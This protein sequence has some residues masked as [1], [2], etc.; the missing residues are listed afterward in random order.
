MDPISI[1]TL[2]ASTT[3]SAYHVSATLYSFINGARRIDAEVEALSQE[4]TGV[5][6][7]LDAIGVVFA[8]PI[9]RSEKATSLEN[10]PIWAAVAG[11]LNDCRVSLERFD[12]QLS[13]SD[14]KPAGRSFL[15]QSLKWM[16]LSF[17]AES[18]DKLRFQMSTHTN[19]LQISLQMQSSVDTIGREY[20]K[21]ERSMSELTLVENTLTPDERKEL[22][23]HTGYLKKTAA[24]V[25]ANLDGPSSLTLNKK[26]Q[27]ASRDLLRQV[28]TDFNHSLYEH[29]DDTSVEESEE[30]EDETSDHEQTLELDLALTLFKNGDIHFGQK[31]W[32]LAET[33]LRE[34]FQHL[35]TVSSGNEHVD[36]E[37]MQLLLIQSCMMQEK[38]Q[39][40]ELMLKL[41]VK[42]RPGR[43]MTLNALQACHLLSQTYLCQYDFDFSLAYCREAL[44]GRKVLLGKEHPLYLASLRLLVF[45]H[46][47]NGDGT[48]AA[49]YA[50]GLSADARHGPLD[51]I[52]ARFSGYSTA[53]HLR[54]TLQEKASAIR[55]LTNE[56]FVG[57][58]KKEQAHDIVWQTT[59]VVSFDP[60]KS[61]IDYG[62]ALWWAVG[63]D[64]EVIVRWLISRGADP[65]T[66]KSGH[67][68]LLKAA[69]LGYAATVHTLCQSGAEINATDYAGRTSLLWASLWGFNETVQILLSHGADVEK[70][71]DSKCTPLMDAALKGHE[72]TVRLLLES[73]ALLERSSERGKTALM[74]A[75]ENSETEVC[76]VLIQHKANV[77]ASNPSGETTLLIA[78]GTREEL[79]LKVLLDAGANVNAK[80]DRGLTALRK[81]A[82]SGRVS[83][84]RL[85][86]DA[87]AEVDVEP[88]GDCTALLECVD[89]GKVDQVKLLLEYGANPERTRYERNAMETAKLRHNQECIDVLT[90]HT[91]GKD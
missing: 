34:G 51:Y 69:G 8:N 60:S 2:C 42:P 26:D 1:I 37:G 82:P 49:A 12:E 31:Q 10:G 89:S 57:Q 58:K 3:A 11:A 4:V 52:M 47:S 32:R 27:E 64:N 62:K 67:S 39:E 36:V 88:E 65:N 71:D 80:D 70:A 87:G 74:L 53:N 44:A 46:L 54:T 84:M 66:S 55:D 33:V 9:V 16:K 90:K 77:N 38:W 22:E 81:L 45:I 7:V 35:E 40:A 21:L 25:L 43:K 91:A 29:Q 78:A 56:G 85:L 19:N 15:K 23:Q 24:A 86:L 41:L 50:R 68:V 83:A 72:S 6:R 14:R 63:S 59:E 17:K 48:S 20:S 30:E 13:P 61:D 18:I 79:L 76:R 73:G 75:A 28:V 5:R